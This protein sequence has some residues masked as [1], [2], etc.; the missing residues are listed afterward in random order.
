VRRGS[1]NARSNTVTNLLNRCTK[2]CG[3]RS[4]RLKG[5]GT[6]STRA[7]WLDCLFEA[8]AA[9]HIPYI[10]RLAEYS[11]ELCGSRELA[12]D[13]ADRLIGITRLALS[14]D[15][16]TRGYFHGTSACMS[17]LFT[18]ERETN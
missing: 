9:D 7:A 13:R 18:A 8:H 15:R 17:A 3:G 10:E 12:S 16:S 6:F 2:W 14:P 11:G 1:L 4:P 5:H